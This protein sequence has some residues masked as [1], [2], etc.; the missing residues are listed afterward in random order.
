VEKSIYL[1][2]CKPGFTHDQFVWRWREHGA[3]AMS[4]TFFQQNS[5]GYTQAEV[6]HPAAIPGADA[7]YNGVAIIVG[8]GHTRTRSEHEQLAEMLVDEFKTFAGPIVPVI[9]RVDETVLKAG[10]LGGTTAFLF[11]LD[12]A[13]AQPVAAHYKDADANRVVLNI[14][15]EAETTG[16][17][18]SEIPYK[19]VIEISARNVEALKGILGGDGAPWRKADL[20]LVTRECVMWDRMS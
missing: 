16:I 13:A 12:P 11:F 15:N 2:K 17:T 9:L 1:T 7:E 14:R 3:L 18:S 4:K 19:A 8:R 20:P 10:P 6:I 5:V